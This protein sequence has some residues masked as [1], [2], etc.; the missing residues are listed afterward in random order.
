[1]GI[2]LV[3]PVTLLTSPEEQRHVI[4]DRGHAELAADSNAC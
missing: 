2:R 3:V 4:T 1:V